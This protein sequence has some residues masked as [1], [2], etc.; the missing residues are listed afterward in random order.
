MYHMLFRKMIIEIIARS[1][2]VVRYLKNCTPIIWISQTRIILPSSF[3]KE[4]S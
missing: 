1:V 2:K 3:G 4:E